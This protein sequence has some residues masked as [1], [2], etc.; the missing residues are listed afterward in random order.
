MRHEVHFD[1]IKNSIG[2]K[3]RVVLG[4]EKAICR[5]KV[6]LKKDLV[7][8]PFSHF[9]AN[10]LLLEINQELFPFPTNPFNSWCMIAP[11]LSLCSSNLV[12][13]FEQRR[14][15]MHFK[16]ALNEWVDN[17]WVRGIS[18]KENGFQLFNYST[19]INLPTTW[20]Y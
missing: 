8:I 10:Y 15:K 1:T 14:P 19:R 9:K 6:L 20:S 7:C 5:G 4:S 3:K 18:T 16:A 2:L 12:S 13:G 11:C 17:D